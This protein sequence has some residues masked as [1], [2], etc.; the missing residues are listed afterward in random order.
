MPSKPNPSDPT[1]TNAAPTDPNATNAAAKATN[2]AP[3]TR[4]ER[5]APFARRRR[6][7]RIVSGVAGFAVVAVAVAVPFLISFPSTTTAA[8]GEIVTPTPADSRL[9]CSGG[10]IDAGDAE[11]LSVIRG[12]AAS[13]AGGAV[14]FETP[15]LAQPDLGGDSTVTR[16]LRIPATDDAA[17]PTPSGVVTQVIGTETLAGLTASACGEA[18]A[19]SWIVAGSTD[20]GNTSVLLLTNASAVSATVDLTIYGEDGAVDA[21]GS[22]GIVVPAATVRMIPLAGLA[23]DLQQPVIR[24]VARG[25]EVASS[26]Q[27]SAISGLTPVGVEVTGPAEAPSTSVVIPGFTIVSPTAVTAS[28]DGTGTAGSPVLRILAPGDTDATVT[29][30]VSNEDPSGVAT[31]TSVVVAAGRA[32]EVPLAGL[33]AGS[34]SIS[35]SSDQPIVAAGRSTS[36]G[37][38]GTDYAWFVS[39]RA[40]TA[41]LSVANTGVAGSTLH[42]RNDG[43][44]TAT[45]TVSSGSGDSSQQIPPATAVSLVIGSDAVVVSSD[46]ALYASVS[47]AEGGRL[48]SYP[49]LPPSPLASE[50]TVYD[51]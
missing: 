20:V 40:D 46:R 36:T 16:V 48:A 3:T 44:E 49:V 17:Q 23:P 21:A 42:L 22:T 4:A 27:S 38:A 7:V 10:F 13:T 31:A 41:P 28:D 2:A 37:D 25:G 24:V 6:L 12:T 19:D 26:L 35:L 45:V 33:A 14:E 39:S 8:G 50:L 9:V 30:R 51:H 5:L 11:T 15:S 1:A 43:Q 34:Y 32:T 47:I 18:A 29:V